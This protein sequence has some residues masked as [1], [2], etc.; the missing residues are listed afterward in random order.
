MITYLPMD[1]PTFPHL[2][3]PILGR[4]EIFDYIVSLF[5]EGI[6]WVLPIGLYHC[7]LLRLPHHIYTCYLLYAPLRSCPPAHTL[8]TLWITCLPTLP[9]IHLP[10]RYY[11][12]PY[13]AA[14]CSGFCLTCICSYLPALHLLRAFFAMPPHT[15]IP[16]CL[17]YGRFG[18]RRRHSC[19]LCMPFLLRMTFP[20]PLPHYRTHSTPCLY[21]CTHTHPYHTLCHTHTPPHTHTTH[22]T[23]PPAT[24]PLHYHSPTPYP[25]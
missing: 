10:E 22:H 24:H 13:A 18:R 7:R 19:Y 6:G 2:R 17:L 12:I 11:I 21:S 15:A 25:T 5:S 4:E 8:P 23:L 20:L 16:V 9:A 3:F 14:T 1:Y